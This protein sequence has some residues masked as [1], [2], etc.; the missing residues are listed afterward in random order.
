MRNTTLLFLLLFCLHR[1]NG[2]RSLSA[3]Y[4]LL[5][6]KKSSQTLQDSKWFQLEPLFGVWKDI[7][8]H[9]IEQAACELMKQ[10]WI[11]PVQERSY[12]L[13]TSGIEQLQNWLSSAPFLKHLNG[14]KYHST[15]TLFWYR[16]SLLVQTLSNVLHHQRFEPIHRHE[17]TFAWVKR[18][19]FSQK[20]K[21]RDLANA[22]YE[23]IRTLLTS[24]SE[25]E[26]TI[27]TL[28]LTSFERIGW[29]NEQLSIF[30]QKDPF[31][32]RLMFQHVLHYM[33][34]N[35]E[36]DKQ[37]FPILYELVGDVSP[38]VPLTLSTQ[39]TYEWLCKGKTLE[40]IAR[41]RK[42][43]RSTIEDHIVE[44]A[45]NISEFSIE[46]FVD[47][48]TISKVTEVA[49]R[50]RTRQLKKIR[51]AVGEDVSYFE[52]RL[53]LAKVGEIYAS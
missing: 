50:L 4:H 44:I 41:L 29:T 3:V 9:E 1:F 25:E 28:R 53:V 45:A 24:L 30:L 32:I 51:E 6:G 31:Y 10:Q 42:L 13:T 38:S 46:P 19:L 20:R 11:I 8:L 43:K 34:A 2:E 37:S 21:V 7:H 40:E 39:K 27:F 52:I 36:A 15:E 17:E 23:E 5:S 16:L 26:A 49:K 22:L 48:E 14:W 12:V 47:T 33:M 18:Y 35:V